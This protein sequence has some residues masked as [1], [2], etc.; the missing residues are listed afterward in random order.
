MS[1]RR[2][3][4]ATHVRPR[5]P[6]SGRPAPA[7]AKGRRPA[8]GRL[9][10]HTPIRRS[11]G[12]PLVGRL[13]LVTAVVAIAVGVL[14]VAVGGANRV[15]ASLSSSVGGFI[16]GVTATPVP[17]ATPIAVSDAPSIEAPSEP[18]TKS[19]S[20]DLVVTVPAGV[21]GDPASR[22]RVYLALASQQQTPIQDVPLAA[23]PRNIIPVTLTKGTNDF[24]VS[25]VGPG[26]ESEQS[27][28]VRYI[29]D[30]SKPSLKVT[31]PN[32]GAIVNGKA[33]KVK[34][35]TQARSTINARNVTSGD[36][37][38]VTAD[39]DGLFT[40]SLPLATGSNE[41][42]LT[43]TDPAGNQKTTTLSVRR[44]SGKLTVALTSSDYHLSRKSLPTSIRLTAVV[45]DPDGRPLQGA[46]VTFTL[47][48]P[49][50]PALTQDARTDANGR[51]V[52]TTTIPSGA[53]VGGGS[54]AVLVT[55]NSYGSKSDSTVITVGK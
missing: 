10:V 27:G 48:I 55:T 30:Q 45:D 53:S 38:I 9:A 37:I 33:V 31:S 51:A 6:S 16:Q 29:L 7:K 3:S 49:G 40:L 12:I 39:G 24:S 13:L 32:D 22:L 54:A 11:R 20:V 50:I 25:I 2:G 23:I 35:K 52:W 1:T 28:I 8:P 21:V 4:P 18:Y 26:G 36:S 15:M 42:R 47:S 41:L 43:S 44:G 5:P 14:Y 34:G 46:S 17:S 19:D